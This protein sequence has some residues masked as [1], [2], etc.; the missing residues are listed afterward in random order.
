MRKLIFTCVASLLLAVTLQAA[1]KKALIVDGQNNHA[2]KETT[3]V[4]KKLLEETKLFTVDVATSPAKGEDMSAFKPDFAAYDVVVL[5]YN[6]DSWG[7]AAKE[8]FEKFVRSGGGVVVYHAADNA[9][10]EW[11]EYN[12]MIAVGGWGNRKADF[13]SAI[14]YREGKPVVEEPKSNCGHHAQ[15]L[16]FQVTAREPKHPILKGLPETWMHVG[17]ELYDTLCGP[18]KDF[19]LLATAH[20]DPANKG[21]DQNEP[22]L[23]TIRHGKGRVFHT[24]MGHDVVAMSCVGFITTFQRGAEWAATGKVTQKVPADFPGADKISKRE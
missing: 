22:M 9:F 7:P 13:G 1:P 20:S 24:A 17:D 16:P 8:A 5:N 3:P 12:E 19:D 14:H 15:R 11:K 23:L 21:T 2:W 18:A 4:L 6:G 10:P